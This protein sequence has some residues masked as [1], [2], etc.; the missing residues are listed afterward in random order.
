MVNIFKN[1]IETFSKFNG[2]TRRPDRQ[3][4]LDLCGFKFKGCFVVDKPE[5]PKLVAEKISKYFNATY[6]KPCHIVYWYGAKNFHGERG[7][8]YWIKSL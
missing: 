4:H 1:K 8:Q 6:K 2:T 3:R 7:Y 5:T